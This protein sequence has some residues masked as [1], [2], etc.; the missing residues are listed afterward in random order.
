M[1]KRH[2]RNLDHCLKCTICHTQCPVVANFP[3]F[4]GPKQLGP[5]LERL[6]LARGEDEVLEIDNILAYCM[7]CKRCDMACPHGVKPAYYNT[8]NKQN[9]KTGA[10]EKF[11]DWI[12]AHNVWWGK[13]ASKIPGFSNFALQFPVAKFGMGMVGLAGRSLPAYN[14]IN[15]KVK[16]EEKEK[17]I[18][19]FTGCYA[20]FNEP[21]I[22]QSAVDIL[23]ACNYEVKLMMGECCGMPVISNAFPDETEKFARKNTENFLEHIKKGYK[24][25]TTCTT[26]ELMLK[27]E[28][29][30]ILKEEDNRELFTNVWGLFELLEGEESLPFDKNKEKIEKAYY[31]IPCH[32]KAQGT[33][34]PAAKLLKEF[35][36]KNLTVVDDYCCGIAGSYGFK[37]EKHRLSLEIGSHLFKAIKDINPS[38]VIT[39]CGTCK[40]QI[41]DGTGISVNHPSVVLREYLKIQ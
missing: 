16:E 24:I 10:G 20:A 32:L 29:R 9:L 39:D 1:S 14:K 30:D 15:I 23:E 2:E 5:E 7:N 6:R 41:K 17:K 4:P 35:A 36:V 22:I 26:C 33:G 12:L 8:K 18:L 31:H 21:E 13:M 28:Y 37:K 34:A 3:E 38:L 27:E 25:L 11:R 40:V 19:Y